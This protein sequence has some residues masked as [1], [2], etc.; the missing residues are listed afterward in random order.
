MSVYHTRKNRN[1]Y[2][3]AKI[4]YINL[5]DDIPQDEVVIFTP[6]EQII[7]RSF[8]NDLRQ[9]EEENAILAA[10]PFGRGT[11]E[12]IMGKI[13]GEDYRLELKK[14]KETNR[15][16]DELAKTT[17]GGR[18]SRKHRKH[19]TKHRKSRKSRK[20][21]KHRKHVTKHKKRKFRSLR[22]SKRK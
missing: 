5:F 18:K 20:S 12:P 9:Q 17:P 6:E 3:L 1:L 8:I 11:R 4:F 14:F 7:V 16:I 19:V 13:V 15:L 2:N 10:R 21:R 22:R